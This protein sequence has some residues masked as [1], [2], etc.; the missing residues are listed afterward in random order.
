MWAHGTSITLAQESPECRVDSGPPGRELV[1]LIAAASAAFVTTCVLTYLLARPGAR[2]Q[3]L[4]HPN[5]RSLHDRPI[6]RTGGLAVLAGIA[7]SG[8]ILATMI[9]VP[10]ILGWM[11]AWMVVIAGVSLLD[12][13]YD[14]SAGWRFAIHGAAAVGVIAAGF[15]LTTVPLPGLAWQWPVWIGI[16]FSIVYVVW[17]INLYNFMDGMDGF[18]GGMTAIGFGTWGVLGWMSD[19]ALFGSTALI[20]GASAVGFLVWNFPPARIFLG[21]VGSSAIGFLVAVFGLW[22]HKGG[23]VPL[24]ASVLVFSPFIVDATVT[25]LRRAWRGERVWRAHRKHYY[26]RL[27]RSGWGHRR[28]VLWEYVLMLTCAGSAVVAVGATVTVQWAICLVWAGLY[29]LILITVD[30]SI[31]FPK[32][33]A[34]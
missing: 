29:A 30:R 25:L 17:I 21:D 26:Q 34:L 22:A 18:A 23:I 1:S 27:A 3:I 12:D 33:E 6:P 14:L 9:D 5:E 2:F 4:D 10:A 11:A 16:G 32:E 8:G 15:S 31:A 7:L 24:W 13:R 19:A 28:T 20:I